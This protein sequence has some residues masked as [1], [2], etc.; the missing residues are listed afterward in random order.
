MA[1]RSYNLDAVIVSQ[2]RRVARWYPPKQECLKRSQRAPDQYECAKCRT[3]FSRECVQIDH[4]LPIVKLSGLTT[5][6]EY[7][8]RMFCGVDGLQTLCLECHSEKTLRENDK[9]RKSK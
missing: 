8:S 3:L 1:K 9:R 4:I 2:L 7:I 6:D 5:W